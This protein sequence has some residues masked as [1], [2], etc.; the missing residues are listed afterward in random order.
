MTNIPFGIFTAIRCFAG[1][2]LCGPQIQVCKEFD[3]FHGDVPSAWVSNISVSTFKARIRKPP[4]RNISVAV[5]RKAAL[6][7][8]CW[9]PGDVYLNRD[10]AYFLINQTSSSSLVDLVKKSI[11]SQ[12]T[13]NFLWSDQPLK[14]RQIAEAFEVEIAPGVPTDI[15]YSSLTTKQAAIVLQQAP[16]DLPPHLWKALLQSY[17]CGLCFRI[18]SLPGRKSRFCYARE[19]RSSVGGIRTGGS[20]DIIAQICDQCRTAIPPANAA[21]RGIRS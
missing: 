16:G 12:I 17:N 11:L 13:A 3:H 2:K 19:P 21:N 1:E 8:D 6:L 10:S 14:V 4:L 5:K 9:D 20:V 7:K 15:I 18:Q